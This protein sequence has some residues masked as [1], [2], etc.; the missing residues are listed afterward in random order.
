MDVSPLSATLSV[1]ETVQLVV[2]PKDATGGALAERPVT[3]SSSNPAAATV[4]AT[5]LV[6]AVAAGTAAI[7]APAT[8]R[9]SEF[10]RSQS[11]ASG[12]GDRL[13][14][15]GREAHSVTARSPHMA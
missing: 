15:P 12:I 10:T 11:L 9:I 3:W 7:A 1:G 8:L 2:T 6:T 14:E 5:G 4:D 13:K